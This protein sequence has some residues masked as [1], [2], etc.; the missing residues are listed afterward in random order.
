MTFVKKELLNVWKPRFL[1]GTRSIVRPMVAIPP[2]FYCLFE[3]FIRHE[4]KKIPSS[5]VLL[6]VVPQWQCISSFVFYILYFTFILHTFTHF[7]YSQTTKK[8]TKYT[9]CTISLAPHT[10]I[11]I[12]LLV[13]V[14]LEYAKNV[15]FVLLNTQSIHSIG[16]SELS[17]EGRILKIRLLMYTLVICLYYDYFS[18]TLPTWYG[19][20]LL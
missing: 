16:T 12:K 3:F 11:W 1:R 6:L 15:H 8:R 5:I 13:F 19:L 10:L 4:S 20:D 18:I 7:G 14:F 9:I 2:K 17:K